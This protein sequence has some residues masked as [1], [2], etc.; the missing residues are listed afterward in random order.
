M[1]LNKTTYTERNERSKVDKFIFIIIL[2]AMYF[3]AYALV[4]WLQVDNI[5]N[6]ILNSNFIIQW[7]TS[8]NNLAGIMKL[9]AG[10]LLLYC[11]IWRAEQVF[12][13]KE[14]GIYY[15]ENVS[16]KVLKE[17]YRLYVFFELP[18]SILLFI[19]YIVLVFNKVEF[20]AITIVIACVFTVIFTFLAIVNRMDYYKN[21][22]GKSERQ[23]NKEEAVTTFQDFMKS[24]TKLV[25]V[26]NPFIIVQYFE[27]FI[28]N[29]SLF[30]TEYH[31][32]FYTKHDTID[33]NEI[34]YSITNTGLSLKIKEIDF[35]NIPAPDKLCSIVISPEKKEIELY[36]EHLS[37]Q[38]EYS[39]SFSL[40][41]SI[42]E[43]SEVL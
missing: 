24:G 41:T 42:S 34:I 6:S 26:Y 9:I 29:G 43:K 38:G 17:D 3:V 25:N 27:N 2:F 18:M 22:Y 4:T 16:L 30:R 15:D 36:I 20:S 19:S 10:V 31:N 11:H 5:N 39:Q 14:N 37:K 32:G 13:E 40:I 21:Y 7:F 35:G 23:I 1:E 28:I 8:L 12:L 33:S